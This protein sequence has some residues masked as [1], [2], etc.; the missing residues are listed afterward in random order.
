MGKARDL[1][2]L[3]N[4]Y[5]L[6]KIKIGP[7]WAN[8]ELKFEA[9]NKYAAWELYVEML[10]RVITQP[11]PAEGGNEQAALDSVYSIFETTREVLR[12]CGPTAFEVSLV[13]IPFLNQVV[14]PFTTKWHSASLSGAFSDATKRTEFRQELIELQHDLCQ[15]NRILAKMAGV[16]DLTDLEQYE[17]QAFI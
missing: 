5:K 16:E 2:G 3:F 13:V 7:R 6:S 10:T 14:R 1:A 15:Y 9:F 17:F 11:M 4:H 8:V 12:R